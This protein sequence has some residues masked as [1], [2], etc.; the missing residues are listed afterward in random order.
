MSTG[1]YRRAFL[2]AILS[3]NATF[4]SFLLQFSHLSL[5]SIYLHS[6]SLPLIFTPRCSCSTP[7]RI[8]KCRGCCQ[9]SNTRCVQTNLHNPR[10][11]GLPFVLLRHARDDY[12]QPV[13]GKFT[14]QI[15][16]A[17]EDAARTMSYTDSETTRSQV[18]TPPILFLGPS[19]FPTLSPFTSHACHPGHWLA[20]EPVAKSFVRRTARPVSLPRRSY[21][22]YP[23]YCSPSILVSR[24]VQLIQCI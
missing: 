1:L 15:R 18:G 3:V 8:T 10:S 6:Y 2:T 5:L 17:L 24:R 4:S 9:A 21:F 22:T 11:C 20:A 12:P 23:S 7:T 16:S 13:A 19:K 14:R